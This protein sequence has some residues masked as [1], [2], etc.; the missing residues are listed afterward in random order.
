M[1]QTGLECLTEDYITSL[2]TGSAS[3][4][5]KPMMSPGSDSSSAG[6]AAIYAP[7]TSLH[8][9]D[10]I[11]L[12]QLSHSSLNGAV[13]GLFNGSIIGASNGEELEA[14]GGAAALPQQEKGQ[15]SPNN[16][17]SPNSN[18]TP[19]GS[20]SLPTPTL[21]P[22]TKPPAPAVKSATARRRGHCKSR[23]G[24]FNCKRR[25]VKCN[26]TRPGCSPCKRL[27]L[28]CE[29]PTAANISPR[30]AGDGADA[31]SR[32][33]SLLRP[34]GGP[35][36]LHFE[37]L[38]FFH[39]FMKVAYPPLPLKGEAVWSEFAA[40]SYNVSQKERRKKRI[41]EYK[42]RAKT[43][44]EMEYARSVQEQRLLCS[45]PRYWFSCQDDLS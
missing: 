19:P 4:M 25:R 16:N 1:Y 43:V 21:D 31:S 33:N 3:S 5:H 18:N 35:S 20:A 36:P 6:S 37:D 22:A 42:K 45:L 24:C 11:N 38:R 15:Q 26:E 9:D 41:I 7:P 10:S 12:A 27:G 8:Q 30:G 23:L 2:S 14:S 17:P 34:Q 29:Y 32:Q 13:N 40:M 44:R 39:Q 28:K